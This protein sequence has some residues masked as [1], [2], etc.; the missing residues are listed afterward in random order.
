MPAVGSAHDGRFDALNASP[1][2]VQLTR[3]VERAIGIVWWTRSPSRSGS[4]VA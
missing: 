1:T 2:Y 3:S 4:D